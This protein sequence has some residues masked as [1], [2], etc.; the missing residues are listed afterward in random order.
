[1]QRYKTIRLLKDNQAPPD[2]LDPFIWFKY[3]Y[4]QYLRIELGRI[5]NKE[6][7][8][9]E[10]EDFRAIDDTKKWILCLSDSDIDR[11]IFKELKKFK[12][13][14]KQEQGKSKKKRRGS[15]K[16]PKSEHKRN[17][18]RTYLEYLI[19]K[20]DSLIRK[21]NE[22]A[23]SQGAVRTFFIEM[24]VEIN[25]MNDNEEGTSKFK[26]GEVGDFELNVYVRYKW[27]LISTDKLAKFLSTYGS[28]WNGSGF[29]KIDT[30]KFQSELAHRFKELIEIE[31]EDLSKVYDVIKIPFEDNTFYI[32]SK[33]NNYEQSKES[34]KRTN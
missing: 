3:H 21:L 33:N 11:N 20:R 12:E 1:M 25:D 31:Q 28:E 34:T 22:S 2:N 19:D 13:Q 27:S 23:S 29:N 17:E 5:L 32:Q 8:K 10:P 26:I 18:N 15:E 4:C 6:P 14:I 16:I 9:I 24:L 7:D 30:T